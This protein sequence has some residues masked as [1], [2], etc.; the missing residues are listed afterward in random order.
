MFLLEKKALVEEKHFRVCFFS[1]SKGEEEK[2]LGPFKL[3]FYELPEKRF[4]EQMAENGR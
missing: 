1:Y 3:I 4:K 2:Y